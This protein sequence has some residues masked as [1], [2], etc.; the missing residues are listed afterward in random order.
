MTLAVLVINVFWLL[1]IAVCVVWWKLN[2]LLGLIVAYV[3]LIV[4]A[5]RF[6][7]GELEKT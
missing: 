6:R 3:P 5:A 2:G 1:P 7:A 4:L